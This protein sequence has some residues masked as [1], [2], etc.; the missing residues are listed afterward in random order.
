MTQDC[1]SSIKGL[2]QPLLDPLHNGRLGRTLVLVKSLDWSKGSSSTETMVFA[3]D[4]GH[5]QYID[6]F[7]I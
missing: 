7:S 2:C 3:N 1:P 5:G 4:V 6:I